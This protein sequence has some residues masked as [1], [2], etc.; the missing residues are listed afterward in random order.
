MA[1][2]QVRGLKAPGTSPAHDELELCDCVAP[3]PDLL[4]RTAG[5]EPAWRPSI[6]G[7]S[8]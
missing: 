3:Y 8:T 2:D 7:G 1:T 5:V 6:P 4:N